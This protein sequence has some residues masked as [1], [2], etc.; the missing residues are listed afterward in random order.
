MDQQKYPEVLKMRC[1]ELVAGKHKG[2]FRGYRNDIP[3]K[4]KN[5]V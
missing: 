1:P 5:H 3:L 2:G 4:K